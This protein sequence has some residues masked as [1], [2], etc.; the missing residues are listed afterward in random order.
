LCHQRLAS[1][2]VPTSLRRLYRER[3]DGQVQKWWDQAEATHDVRLLRRIVQEAFCSRLADRALDALGDLAFE[4]GDF[5]EAGYW[6]RLLAP[7]NAKHGLADLAFPDPQIDVARVH[8]KLLLL[9]LARGDRAGI[10]AALQ[11][12]QALHGKAEG[13]LAGRKGNYLET[14][15]ALARQPRFMAP[16]LEDPPWTTFAGDPSRNHLIPKAP[17]PYLVEQP[18]MQLRNSRAKPATAACYPVIAGGQVL[19]AGPR[20]VVGYDLRLGRPSGRYDL[21]DDGN[22]GLPIG[23]ADWKARLSAGSRF[24]LSVAGKH[25]YVRLGNTTATSSGAPGRQ[26]RTGADSFLVCLDLQPDRQG[27]YPERWIVAAPG[28]KGE[29]ER[30]AFEGSPLVHEGRVYVAQS[31]STGTRV[32]TAIESYNAAKGTRHWHQDVCE[33]RELSDGEPHGRLHL[34]TLAGPNVVYCSHSGAIVAVDTITGRRS[35][36]TRY[37]SRGLNT[38]SGPSARDLAPCIYAGGRLFAAPA[39]ADRLFCLEAATGQGVW[40]SQRIEAVHL[41]GVAN[42]KLIFTTERGI[43]AADAATGEGLIDWLIPATGEGELPSLGRGL[44]AGG[45]VYWPTWEKQAGLPNH[46]YVLQQEDGQP[47]ADNYDFSLRFGQ[48]LGNLVLGEGCL[49]I[50]TADQLRV[51]VPAARGLEEFRNSGFGRPAPR[52]ADAIGLG[53]R[54]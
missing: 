27:K 30:S 33:T 49:A 54:P 25:I 36:A 40:E 15:Q 22:R 32:V 23:R 39:D 14:L 35:W 18:P 16:A 37:P 5:E 20:W 43:R 6:W 28:S 34:L 52:G 46:L 13:D 31:R 26:E 42:G 51:F 2:T 11:A 3:V 8:A 47:D 9:R 4:R 17:S 7:E 48:A 24:T 38:A 19:V 10:E 53:C 44:L 29:Q 41:L 1:P 21:S 50:A 45:R 12:Y